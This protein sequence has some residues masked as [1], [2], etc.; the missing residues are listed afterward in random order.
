MHDKTLYKGSFTNDVI[1]L[2]GRGG[3]QIMT[4][5]DRGEGGGLAVDDVILKLSF[6]AEFLIFLA[7]FMT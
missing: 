6:L 2:G 3:F 7:K 4:A 5:D 1:D